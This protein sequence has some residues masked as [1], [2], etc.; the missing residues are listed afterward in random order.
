VTGVLSLT[1][2]VDTPLTDDLSIVNMAYISDAAG[3]RDWAGWT[4]IVSSSLKLKS[5]VYLPLVL[6][7]EIVKN[8]SFETGDTS[9]W[10]TQGDG[11]LPAPTVVMTDPHGGDFHLLLGDPSYCYAPNPAQQGHHISVVSQTAHIPKL[12]GTPIL[13]FSYRVFTYD[14]LTWTGGKTGDSLDVYVGNQ[15][16]LQ[17][18]Y[19]NFPLPA[20]GCDDLQDSGWRTPDDPW[21]GDVYPDALDLSEWKGTSVELR[22]ELI[23]RWDGYFNTWAY[24]D[25][26]RV[27]IIP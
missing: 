8:G 7:S 2:Q 3:Q 24:L 15:L 11:V 5:W 26:V 17:D 18:N 19:E 13:T 20:P 6:R 12:T 14:H 23:T 1:V 16:A 21:G 25:E 22:F 9:G 4:T 27:E 10:H